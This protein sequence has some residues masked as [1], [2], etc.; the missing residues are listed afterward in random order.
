MKKILIILITFLL[1]SNVLVAS[2]TDCTGIK[3]LGYKYFG[4]GR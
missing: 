1:S 4:I 3:K 2:E